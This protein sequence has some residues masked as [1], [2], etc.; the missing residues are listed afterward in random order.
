MV[1]TLF[2]FFPY[3]AQANSIYT[4]KGILQGNTLEVLIPKHDTN[5]VEGSFVEKAIT[6]YEI[7]NKPNWDEAISRSEFLKLMF[8]NYDFGEINANLAKPFPDV[9]E[10]HPFFE[11]IQKASALDII[12]G[13]EDGLFRPYTPITRGQ[14]AKILVRAFDPQN[15]SNEEVNFEDVPGDHRFYEYIQRSVRAKYFQGYPDGFM[16]PDRNI[17]FSEAE[18]VIT[19][20]GEVE[21][22][23]EIASKTYFRAFIGIHRL[24][25][26]GIKN[27]NLTFQKENGETENE[28]LEI[29]VVYR[30][31]STR[32]FTM[33]E[34]KT[35]LF[36]ET[37]QDNTWTMINN[38]K[39][40]TNE[41]QLWEGDFIVPT[42]GIIT[43]EYG[44]KLYINGSYSGSHFGIDYANDEGTEIYASNKGIIT[45]ADET[46]SYGNTIVVDHGHNIFTMYL[47][48]S[49]LK[50]EKGQEVQKGDLI[51]LMGSTG[52][53]TGSHLHFTHFIGD[54]IVDSDEWFKLNY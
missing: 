7:E 43:L 16:R 25:D 32:S 46:M 30:E 12:H 23:I 45:L 17:N 35:K 24:S 9:S 8:D 48:L 31:F 26:A 27:L 18:I 34:N 5:N 1:S 54:I 39:S 44:N 28:S 29:N 4:K 36:G 21:N 6:F 41:A 52:I 20:A 47:H 42:E 37:E 51:G 2:F 40:S 11:Y 3:A 38:A 10:V 50:V 53:A 49:E 22:F 33:E 14:I 13:Y 19:R 15:L